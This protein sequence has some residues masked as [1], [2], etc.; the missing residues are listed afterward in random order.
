MTMWN[1]K[2]SMAI[3][4]AA[5]EA[6]EPLTVTENEIRERLDALIKET[7]TRRGTMAG[8]GEYRLLCRALDKMQA[9]A[10]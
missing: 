4:L 6:G 8:N 9:E 2:Q 7:Q 5:A 3:I 1:P 10:A